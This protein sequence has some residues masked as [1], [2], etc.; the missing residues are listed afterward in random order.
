MKNIF[1]SS[2]AANEGHPGVT[3][4]KAISE[5]YTINL[6]RIV[7]CHEL[8]FNYNRGFEFLSFYFCNKKKQTMLQKGCLL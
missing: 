5:R 1:T 7:Q 4:Y 6:I 2:E 8:L 3:N